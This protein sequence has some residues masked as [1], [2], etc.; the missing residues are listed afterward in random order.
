MA[1]AGWQVAIG[2]DEEEDRLIRI[3]HM[4][5]LRPEQIPPVLKALD[6]ALP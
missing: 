2:L 1:E 4:G 6:Q 3:G 5:D